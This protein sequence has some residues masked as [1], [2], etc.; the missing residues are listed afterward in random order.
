MLCSKLHFHKDFHVILCSYT[1][2]LRLA[3]GV[4]GA[5]RPVQHRHVPVGMHRGTRG[6]LP[7][8]PGVELR[9]NLKSISNRCPISEVAFVWELTKETIHLPLGCL[10][11]GH[12]NR[13]SWRKATH[14]TPTRARGN[15]S[16]DT[17]YPFELES[18]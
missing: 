14:T 7:P 13:C 10:Q 17:R 11:G 15:A 1:I 2:R 12:R 8:Y 9:A 5:R 18:V 6:T 4:L 3:I 16:R